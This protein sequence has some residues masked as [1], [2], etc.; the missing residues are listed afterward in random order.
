MPIRFPEVTGYS[1]WSQ[2]YNGSFN[3]GYIKDGQNPNMDLAG[4]INAIL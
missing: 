2:L 3:P 1:Q 4:L